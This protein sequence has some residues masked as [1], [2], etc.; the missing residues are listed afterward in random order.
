[1]VRFEINFAGGVNGVSD[2]LNVRYEEELMVSCVLSLKNWVKI[3][4]NY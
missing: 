1:M 4:T 3:E 2:E